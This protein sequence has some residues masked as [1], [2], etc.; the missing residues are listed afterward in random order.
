MIADKLNVLE[1]GEI[2][3]IQ[4]KSTREDVTR[5]IL[6]R[7]E[8]IEATFTE[9]EYLKIDLTHSEILG[10][11]SHSMLGTMKIGDLPAMDYVIRHNDKYRKADIFNLGNVDDLYKKIEI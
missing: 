2:K 6:D 4:K 11:K 1:L 10:L 5:L 3:E 8:D 9:N 7:Q